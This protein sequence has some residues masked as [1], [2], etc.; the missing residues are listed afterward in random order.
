MGRFY[1]I[2]GMRFCVTAPEGEGFEDDGI[3][4]NFR[5]EPTAEYYEISLRLVEQA[6]PPEG[7][8]ASSVIEV[9]SGLPPLVY[10]AY[11]M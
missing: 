2:A 10:R 7:E 9:W 4:T 3:L 1:Q 6:E 11:L 8:L 5:T